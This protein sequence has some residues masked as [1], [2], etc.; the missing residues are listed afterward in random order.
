MYPGSTA[1][2]VVD[3]NRAD[4]SLQQCSDRRP[5]E[6]ELTLEGVLE[7]VTSRPAPR[8]LHHPPASLEMRV[9]EIVGRS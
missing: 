9:G 4:Q 2:E 3:A 8:L 5:R 6:G 1:V 7:E